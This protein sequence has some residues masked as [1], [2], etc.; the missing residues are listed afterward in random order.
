MSD[1]NDIEDSAGIANLRKEFEA[2]AK[3]LEALQAELNGYKAKER[4]GTVESVL[5]AKGLEDRA[6]A[7]AKLYR[8]EDVSE[9]AVGKWLEENATAFGVTQQSNQPDPN[10]DAA[11]RLAAASY[12][13]PATTPIQGQ[14]LPLGN[15]EELAHLIKTQPFEELVK[16]GLMPAHDPYGNRR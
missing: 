14:Q 13:Q 12:G 5:K 8:D 11:A 4:V 6:T 16:L 15:P 1:D 9:D 2:R 7:V 3:Q 10:A